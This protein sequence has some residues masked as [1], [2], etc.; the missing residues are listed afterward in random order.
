MPQINTNPT[1]RMNYLTRLN[2]EV[3]SAGR[4]VSN[5]AVQNPNNNAVPNS[6]RIIANDINGPSI[7]NSNK[8]L[9]VETQRV[10]KTQQYK[11]SNN[12]DELKFAA[13]SSTLVN[14][15]NSKAGN[16]QIGSLLDYLM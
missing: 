16:I 14:V 15:G 12:S 9:S 2:T 11:T 5:L 6:L 4:H 8:Q 10:A 13:N 7:E 1:F 3:L